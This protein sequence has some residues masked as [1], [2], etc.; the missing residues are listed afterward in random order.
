MSLIR[1]NPKKSS[2]VN[3]FQELANLERELFRDSFFPLWD[4]SIESLSN[5]AWYPA[6]DIQEDKD[7]V[8]IKADLPGL[9]KEDIEVSLDNN[10]LT[11]RGERQ[12]EEEKNEK[13]YHRVERSYGVFERRI[14]LGIDV[15]GGKV[16][17]GYKEGVLQIVLPKTHESVQKKID[18][19]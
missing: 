10:V 4:K 15:D 3:P 16:D 5:S 8:T 6:I 14:N 17:A 7:N 18:V 13:N 9:K 12:F 1:W 19:K 2:C 11:I